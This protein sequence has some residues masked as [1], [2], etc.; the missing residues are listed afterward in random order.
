MKSII[1]KSFAFIMSCALLLS[2]AQFPSYAASP[3][4]TIQLADA[5]YLHKNSFFS[6]AAEGD[7]NENFFVYTPNSAVTP[8]LAHGNDVAGA[9]SMA[10]VFRL[11]SE[12]GNTLI[13][14]ANADYFTMANGVPIGLEIKDGIIKSSA[15]FKFP[16]VGFTADGRA[17]IGR[18]RLTVSLRNVSKDVLLEDINY[19]KALSDEGGAVVFSRAFEETNRASGESLNV[20]VSINGGEA[21]ANSSI[22]GTVREIFDSSAAVEL[23]DNE[24]LISIYRSSYVETQDRLAQF[25]AGD[26]IELHFAM[27]EAWSNVTQA[28]GGKEMLVNSGIPEKFSDSKRAPRTAIGI[29]GDGTVVVYSCDGRE[30]G[31]SK[32]LELTEL[33]RRMTQLGCVTAVN[34]DGGA[35]T[36]V[37]ATI[38][39]NET[40]EQININSG[41]RL[42]SCSNYICFKNNLSPTGEIASLIADPAEKIVVVDGEEALS[43]KA[44]DTHWYPVKVDASLL[45]YE[46]DSSLGSVENGIFKASS[47]A[48]EGMLT[49]SINGKSVGVKLK[50]V[51]D[52]PLIEG[53]YSDA[54][55]TAFVK[56]PLEQG[57]STANIKL[58]LDGKETE[59]SYSADSG[60]L[61]AP[62]TEDGLLHHAVITVTN[63][64]GHVSR[65]GIE[66]MTKLPPSPD[67]QS[68]EAPAERIFADMNESNWSLKYAE[69]LYRNGIISGSVKNDKRYYYPGAN[70]TRQEFAK[71][72]ASWQGVELSQ[73]ETVQLDFADGA[74][75]ADWALP[76]IKAVVSLGIMSGT[77]ENGTPMFKPEAYISRQEVMTV[78]GKLLGSGYESAELSGFTDSGDVAFWAYP[79]VQLLVKQGVITGSDG[80]LAPKGNMTREQVAKVI[81][82]IN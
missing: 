32:G 38:P 29:K 43:F 12:A 60:L 34:L 17:M 65:K 51:S 59:Y 70:M 5:L 8:Y 19:N 13:A 45:S 31:G 6:A 41:V 53:S 63:D 42:R 56:D 14:A 48:G 73:Y 81:Y 26:S 3:E 50:L 67:G 33:A 10:R 46:L 39:G 66:I 49:A 18:S 82:E 22:Y 15:S 9:A 55:I 40:N 80:R 35:S 16:E 52:W 4:Q 37:F 64:R 79:Y 36:Q 76:Y 62:V 25:S 27:D 75:I 57:F 30:A 2:M 72:I 20:A 77:T 78:I 74:K 1:K 24:L 47:A 54:Y 58:T 69:Y 68:A 28:F 11:E 71:V 21:R 7:I 61:T 44:V 23:Q